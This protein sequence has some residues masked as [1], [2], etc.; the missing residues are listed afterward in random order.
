MISKSLLLTGC[1]IIAVSSLAVGLQPEDEVTDDNKEGEPNRLRQDLSLPK[2]PTVGQ[3]QPSASL[4]S[5]KRAEHPVRIDAPSEKGGVDPIAL[6][7]RNSISKRQTLV[8]WLVDRSPSNSPRQKQLLKRIDG[9]YKDLN[10]TRGDSS[11]RLL[12]SVV[13]FGSNV[14]LQ[15]KKPSDDIKEVKKAISTIPADSTGVEQCFQAVIFAAERFK[16]IDKTRAC[17]ESS[18][19]LCQQVVSWW[20]ARCSSWRDRPCLAIT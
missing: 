7:I 20:I 12:S 3:V 1:L 17:F 5:V 16:A 9:I 19:G 18:S 11:A 6:E 13:A 8:V 15:M 4:S 10:K 2:A 14:T